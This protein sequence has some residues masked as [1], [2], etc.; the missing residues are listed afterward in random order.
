MMQL[1]ANVRNLVGVNGMFYRFCLS[2]SQISR[3]KTQRKSGNSCQMAESAGLHAII[4]L[5]D[6]KFIL[7]RQWNEF[8][9]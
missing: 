8:H 9:G 3:I 5:T 4:T 7:R 1:F 2:F 6:L